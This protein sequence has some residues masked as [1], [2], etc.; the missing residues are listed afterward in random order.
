MVVITALPLLFL[1]AM[2]LPLN[3]NVEIMKLPG[4]LFSTKRDRLYILLSLQIL[5]FFT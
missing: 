1:D 4:H 5:G 2:I 3:Y